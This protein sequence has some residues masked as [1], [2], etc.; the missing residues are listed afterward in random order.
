MSNGD[1]FDLSILV[2]F[3]E[4]WAVSKAEALLRYNVTRDQ[5]EKIMALSH[6][7]LFDLAGQGIRSLSLSAPH[8]R[9]QLSLVA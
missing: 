5:A 7:E 3:R 6:A 4:M 1:Q 9:P 8:A 2:L